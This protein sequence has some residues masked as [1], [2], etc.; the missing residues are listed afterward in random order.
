M[1]DRISRA[2][3]FD[4][5]HYAK[6]QERRVKVQQHDPNGHENISSSVIYDPYHFLGIK[7]GKIFVFSENIHALCA[8]I[9]TICAIFFSTFVNLALSVVHLW[10][11][12][13]YNMISCLNH[14]DHVLYIELLVNVDS[15]L[16]F[17]ATI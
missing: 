17:F 11:L 8:K 14:D 6:F 15:Y 12:K 10:S 4:R 3:A 2:T 5:N 13:A 1:I 9:M 16:L 7:T